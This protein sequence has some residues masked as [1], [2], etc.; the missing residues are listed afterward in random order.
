MDKVLSQNRWEGIKI[1][2]SV[3]FFLAYR[4]LR[5]ANPWTTLLIV[6][7]MMLTFLN[8]VVI[9]GILVGLIEGSENANKD[10]YTS[11]VIISPLTERQYIRESP[12]IEKVV[13]SAPGFVA[14]TTRYVEGGTVISN[15]KDTLRP[16]QAYNKAGGS[17]AGID[18]EKEDQVTNLSS[19]VVEGEYLEA[20][21]TDSILIG[22]SLLFK[23]TPI[24]SPGFTVLKNVE[25]GDRVKITVNENSREMF[26][27]GIVKSKVGEVD[28]R[29]FM[30]E[31]ELRKLINRSDLNV[32]EM[33]IDVSDSYGADSFK[34]YLIANGVDDYARVQTWEDAQ[35]KFLKDIKITFALLGNVI[36]S[37]GLVVACITIFIVIFVNAITRR[38][39]I[40]ILK[41][42]GVTRGAIEISYVL[43][44]IF[45]ALV[46]V[47]L[48]MIIVFVMLKPALDANPI[49]F[50]FS[51]G[52]L[53]ATLG[54]TLFRALILFIATLIA[55]YIPAYIVIKQNTLNAILG[56]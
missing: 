17:F 53:V 56:R 20:G 5:R 33:A 2:V 14:L 13:E 34:S 7:V 24:E 19:T 51:D 9:S 16:D 6:F 44:A 38:R 11:D 40:G 52:I 36:S 30:L 37:I 46:G 21:D 26:V 42:I 4:E 49:D 31:G 43:Q 10:L 48:G 25:V 45:Y 12:R 1:A 39:Y 15:Y 27:K 54:G 41:G 35:P 29:V 23:Y 55:G 32:D 22:A 3:G 18:P 47:V 8:L 50:P 28:A